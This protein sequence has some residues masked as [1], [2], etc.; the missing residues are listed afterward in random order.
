MRSLRAF[1]LSLLGVALA[2]CQPSGDADYATFYQPAQ[3]ERP[4]TANLL[5]ATPEE[6]ARARARDN[7][8]YQAELARQTM[9]AGSLSAQQAARRGAR[10]DRQAQTLSQAQRDLAWAQRDA[11]RA[12]RE[13]RTA[14][15]LD[16]RP[17]GTDPTDRAD[18]L[19]RSEALE[20]RRALDR[21]ER[22]ARVA[23]RAADRLDRL[24]DVESAAERIR[25][26]DRIA[27]REAERERAARQGPPDPLQRYLPYRRTGESAESL[28]SRVQAAEDRA[29]A[30]GR[31]VESLLRAPDE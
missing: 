12:A 26:M 8:V 23:A 10:L 30:T 19:R 11:E 3:L 1:M 6:V 31:P 25:V 14:E 9:L 4:A 2:A 13:L 27:R 21:Q 29:A 28:R 16:R 20:A 17:V 7:A 22:A 24:G 15:R 18:A 5:A